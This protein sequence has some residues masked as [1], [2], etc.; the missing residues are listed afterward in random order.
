[1]YRYCRQTDRPTDRQTHCHYFYYKLTPN[2]YYRAVCYNF[3]SV[4]LFWLSLADRQVNQPTNQ[5]QSVSSHPSIHPFIQLLLVSWYSGI[6]TTQMCNSV[7]NIFLFAINCYTLQVAAIPQQ[8]LPP[9]SSSSSSSPSSEPPTRQF[10]T[11]SHW[12][13]CEGKGK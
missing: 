3:G 7:W 2:V 5:P 10:N 6:A 9:P 8:P 4:A 12:R 13:L 11:T 1:M